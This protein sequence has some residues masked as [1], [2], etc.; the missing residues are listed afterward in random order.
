[1]PPGSNPLNMTL[2]PGIPCSSIPARILPLKWFLALTTTVEICLLFWTFLF[3]AGPTQSPLKSPL[4]SYVFASEVEDKLIRYPA[5]SLLWPLCRR[6]HVQADGCESLQVIHADFGV[7]FNSWLAIKHHGDLDLEWQTCSIKSA[8]R[9]GAE[10]SPTVSGG[11]PT[12]LEG[13]LLV[14]RDPYLPPSLY[15]LTY[16]RSVRGR[17]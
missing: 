15:L 16:S 9:R 12:C 10:C 1:M 8:L 7:H 17:S 4:C 6:L 13:P 11:I 3:E 14:W 2:T 5:P